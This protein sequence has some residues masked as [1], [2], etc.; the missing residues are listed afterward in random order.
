MKQLF[1]KI[2]A[3]LE[4]LG[5]FGNPVLVTILRLGLLKLPVFPYRITS[6]GATYKLLARPESIKH[7]DLNIL[8]TVLVEEEYKLLREFLPKGPLRMV[9]I[10]AN[11]GSFTM[12]IEKIR[13]L[14]EAFCFEPD[15]GSFNLCRFNLAANDCVAAVAIPMALGG[16]SREIDM[17]VSSNQPCS[18]NIYGKP[19][20][21]AHETKKVQ[22][23]AL[24]EWLE[25]VEGDFDLLKMD[26]EGAEWEI[27]RN[28]PR[29]SLRRFKLI[30]AELHGD[31]TQ[32]TPITECRRILEEAGFE[33]LLDENRYHGLYIARRKE[34]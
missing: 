11:L 5:H 14:S 15:P 32:D 2:Q 25:S 18:H 6:R 29:E 34:A 17:W 7:S 30:L 9:D 24:K 28:T 21:V 19:S 13:G 10:G 3:W 4:I 20:G 23:L 27:L 31:P 33:T 16:A 8:R 26:C 12:W 22:V 1:L